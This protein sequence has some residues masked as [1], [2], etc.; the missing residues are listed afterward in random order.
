MS[1]LPRELQGKRVGAQQHNPTRSH[2]HT[3]DEA[4]SYYSLQVKSFIVN[5]N[6]QR[7]FKTVYIISCD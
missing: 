4:T 1:G 3:T 5:F 7:Q 2:Q 6:I